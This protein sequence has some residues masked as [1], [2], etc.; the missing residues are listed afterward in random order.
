MILADSG[1]LIAAANARDRHHARCSSLVRQYRGALLVSPL[2]VAEV[3]YMIGKLAGREAKAEFLDA[4]TAGALIM[5]T[6]APVD[7]SRMAELIRRYPEL[8]LDSADA[9]IVALAERL[10]LDTVATIDHRDFSVIRPSHCPAF[11][12]L[13]L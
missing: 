3:C 6:L 7:I 4:F 12:L 2:V 11:S 13:P 9:S 8:D 1:V 10:H 5:A